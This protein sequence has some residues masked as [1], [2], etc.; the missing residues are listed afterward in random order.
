MT[1]QMHKNSTYTKLHKYSEWAINSVARALKKVI[2]EEKLK[3]KKAEKIY[4]DIH[5]FPTSPEV[6][7][8]V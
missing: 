3:Q 6:I 1:T 5:H 7:H 4:T 2:V 8:F